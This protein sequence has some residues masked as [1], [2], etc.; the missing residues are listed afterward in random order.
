[1]STPAP[2]PGFSLSNCYAGSANNTIDRIILGLLVLLILLSPLPF[3]A[4]EQSSIFAI[5]MIA[6]SC[7][8]LWLIKLF[9]FGDRKALEN[10]RRKHREQKVLLRKTPFFHRR[11][12][13]AT[14]IR[15]ATLGRWPKKNPSFAI[16]EEDGE[17]GPTEVFSYYSLF[18]Y[19]V[20]RTGIEKI[21]L[22]F[23]LILVFQLVVW[24]DLLVRLISPNTD[25]LYQSASQAAGISVFSYPF[26]LNWFATFSKLLQYVSYF[27]LYV[28]T[29]NVV[30]T[31]SFYIILFYS[32]IASALFQSA[33]GIYELF[34]GGQKIFGYKKVYFLNSASG[35]FINRNHY[36]VYIGL[37]LPLL[38]SLIASRFILLQPAKGNVFI[39]IIRVLDA[40]K[41]RI[42]LPFYFMSVIAAGIAFSL[43]LTGMIP[44]LI[45]CAVFIYLYGRIKENRRIYWITALSVL[46]IVFIAWVSS[47]QLR[48]RIE[49]IPGEVVSERSRF[50]AWK[51]TVRMFLHFP[52]TGTGSGTFREVFPVYRQF[53]TDSIYSETHNEYLQNLS[54]HGFLMLFLLAAF[55]YVVAVRFHR[56]M[57]TPISRLMVFQ[58]GAFCA[59]LIIALH[60]SIDFSFQ[61]PAIAVTGVILA[62]LFFGKYRTENKLNASS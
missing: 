22:S 43:S 7:L 15:F 53:G 9:F 35:T 28:V 25:R 31:R 26:S 38:M 23:C 30:R 5:E 8:L 11:S 34:S 12:S 59:L 17:S 20:R 40:N 24:P 45:S 29:V 21:A 39:R 14:W 44:V 33:Y 56:I 57:R 49:G 62:A 46:A 4:V 50:M 60:N 55:F 54:E 48:H 42:V 19:P 51:D 61:I 47:D 27:M 13:L 37:A 16:V 52:I 36:A 18:G 1:M 3:G 41:G 2:E 10:F 32:V 58:I 6:T